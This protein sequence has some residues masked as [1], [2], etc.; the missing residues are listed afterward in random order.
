MEPGQAL[1]LG[2]FVVLVVLLVAAYAWYHQYGWTPFS[3]AG[4]VPYVRSSP[5]TANPDGG[6]CPKGKTCCPKGQSC[7]G[8]QC[9]AQCD[10]DGDCPS[11]QVCVGGHCQPADIPSW[12]AAEGEDIASLRFKNCVFTVVD[13]AG[14]KHSADV[15]TVLNGMAVAF[16]GATSR[17][18]A[19][20][21]LDRPLNAFSFVIPEVND[22]A[23]VLTAADAAKWAG[24]ATSLTGT[25]RTI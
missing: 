20:L 2:L 3:F 24:A 12:K 6:K 4:V 5:C 8:N 18:P 9:V 17:V 13:P 21:Y 11:G 15:T 14:K 22:S 7:I 1:V 23:T 25:V 16:R 10:T 19:T